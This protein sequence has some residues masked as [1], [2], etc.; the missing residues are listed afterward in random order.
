MKKNTQV[1]TAQKSQA[2]NKIQPEN[3]QK[4]LKRIDEIRKNK[5]KVPTGKVTLLKETEARKKAREEEYRNFR[6]NS[7][8][9]RCKRMG[10]DEK[11]TEEFVKKL[12]EQMEKPNTYT[13]LVMMKAKDGAMMKEALAKANI[14]Y[15]Y[16]GDTYFSFEGDKKLLDKLREIAPPGAKFHIY[17]KKAESVLPKADKEVI[18]KPTNNTAEKKAAAKAI[19]F[20]GRGSVRAIHRMQ[21]GRL[22]D[23]ETGKLKPIRLHGSEKFNKNGKLIPRRKPSAR[24]NAGTNKTKVKIGKRA[25][26]KAH[27][28]QAILSLAERIKQQK[29]ITVQLK[30]KK[31][32]TGSKKA[33]TDVKKAA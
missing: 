3:V 27:T 18:K 23:S 7:L 15:K 10:Y 32:S 16:H 2:T 6:I 30:A 9:R 19:R 4:D 31:S 21:K 8:K 22:K 20:K 12:I 26:L 17:A 28:T 5:S 24:P 1:E 33:S 25:W 11:Q 14:K 13:I 29:A